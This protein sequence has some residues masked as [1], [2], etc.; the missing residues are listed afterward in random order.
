MRPWTEMPQ[1]KYLQLWNPR[2]DFVPP[3]ELRYKFVYFVFRVWNFRVPVGLVDSNG[4]HRVKLHNMGGVWFAV[5]IRWVQHQFS[6]L[7][8]NMTYCNI[9][10]T[11]QFISFCKFTKERHLRVSAMFSV[12]WILDFRHCHLCA[13]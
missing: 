12:F 9:Q 5:I 7:N 10:S 13:L 3:Y 1:Y 2:I 11:Q 4:F 6:F 8:F